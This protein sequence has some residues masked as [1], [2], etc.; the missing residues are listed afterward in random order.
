MLSKIAAAIAARRQRDLPPTTP[1]TGDI[2]REQAGEI[3]AASPAARIVHW[4]V[5]FAVS[6]SAAGTLT[7]VAANY[8]DNPAS[9][10]SLAAGERAKDLVAMSAALGWLV[11]V[12]NAIPGSGMGRRAA[13][14]RPVTKD[15]NRAGYVSAGWRRRL[16]KAALGLL[17][18]LPALCAL[19]YMHPWW[20]IPIAILLALLL[21]SAPAA[22]TLIRKTRPDSGYASLTDLL[23]GVRWSRIVPPPAEPSLQASVRSGNRRRRRRKRK[24]G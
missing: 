6:F 24:R 14:I 10:V 22:V 4:A 1:G 20:W 9:A 2:T 21:E 8:T 16:A 12:L 19:R 15:R 3:N 13:R 7:L 5:D 11:G 23:T 18:T 17:L